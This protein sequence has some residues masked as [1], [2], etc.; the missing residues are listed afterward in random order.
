MQ[1]YVLGGSTHAFTEPVLAELRQLKE[2]HGG[3]VVL[4]DCDV[5]GRQAR[6]QLETQLPGCLHAFVPA[7]LAT[8]ATS[9]E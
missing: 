3:L 6:N 5:A 1:V 8:S 9:K 7:P 2:R 4:T